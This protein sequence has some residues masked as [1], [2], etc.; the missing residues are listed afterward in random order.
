[1]PRV[2]ARPR[3]AVTQPVGC[4]LSVSPAGAVLCGG[5][6]PWPSSLVLAAETGPDISRPGQA[7]QPA[8]AERTR[9]G[10]QL[11]ARTEPSR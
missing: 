7:I 8:A 11:A 5:L 9:V 1:M 10:S 3:E 2:V 4:P 6:S